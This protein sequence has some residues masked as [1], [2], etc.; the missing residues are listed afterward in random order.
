MKKN[1]LIVFDIG[2]VLLRFSKDRARR[3]FERIEP[4][5]GGPLVR[6]MWESPLGVDLERGRL[7]GRDFLRKVPVRMGYRAFA[8]AFR[9]IFT[10]LRQNLR[11]LEHLSKTH[12]T[13]L[14]SNTSDIHW[15]YLFKTYPALKSARWKFGSHRLKLMKPDPRV[16]RILSRKTGYDFRDIVYVDDHPDFIRAAQRLGIRGVC[17]DGKVPLKTLF[18]REGVR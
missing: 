6:A 14:L 5:T 17:Y 18:A 1:T 8:D 16:Y 11:L 9:D 10:P 12:D 13:A 3:N 4:G 7:T 15:P 2:N